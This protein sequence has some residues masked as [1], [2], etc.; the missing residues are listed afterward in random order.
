LDYIFNPCGPD[1]PQLAAG[2]FNAILATALLLT[3]LLLTW[4]LLLAL[5]HTPLLWVLGLALLF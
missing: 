1:S 4:L 3:W 2:S 5:R